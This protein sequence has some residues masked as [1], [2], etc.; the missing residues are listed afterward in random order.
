MNVFPSHSCRISDAMKIDTAA[1]IPLLMDSTMIVSDDMEHA[2]ITDRSGQYNLSK[3]EAKNSID[4]H[5]AE[6]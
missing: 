6:V 2:I 1:L 4:V 5:Q 3:T